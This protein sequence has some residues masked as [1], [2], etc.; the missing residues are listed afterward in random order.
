[1]PARRVTLTLLLLPFLSCDALAQGLNNEHEIDQEDLV[2]VFDLLGVEVYKFPVKSRSADSYANVVIE[3]YVDGEMVE[4]DDFYASSKPI[5]DMMDEPL[6]QIIT[7]MGEEERWIRFYFHVQDTTLSLYTVNGGTK[8][9]TPLSLD[10]FKAWGSRSFD[11]LPEYFA[12]RERLVVFYAN[13]EGSVMSC[14]GTATPEQIASMYDLAVI[15]YL[16]PLTIA[17]E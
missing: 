5:L 7:K 14:P 1:M 10:G 8:Q 15:A 17:Q 12:D 11:D 6:D 4:S 2:N 3:R 16:E 13:R 9:K